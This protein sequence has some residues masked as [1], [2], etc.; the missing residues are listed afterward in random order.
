MKI[1]SSLVIMLMV[2]SVSLALV[3][4][5]NH[6]GDASKIT[7][8]RVV[9]PSNSE[10][11]WRQTWDEL[12]I[13]H[14]VPETYEA[15]IKNHVNELGCYIVFHY[16][17]Y[18]TLAQSLINKQHPEFMFGVIRD[19][20]SKIGLGILQDDGLTEQVQKVLNGRSQR[21]N[22]VLFFWNPEKL[23]QGIKELDHERIFPYHDKFNEFVSL[24]NKICHTKLRPIPIHDEL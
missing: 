20:T 21:H 15:A 6:V 17:T 18:D 9:I 16:A 22:Y 24:T 4:P 13:E 11:H 14:L 1:A 10:Y 2:V 5:P 3:L 19:D 12:N 8:K 7:T 23:A